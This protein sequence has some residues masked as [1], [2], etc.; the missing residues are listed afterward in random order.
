MRQP[1]PG[2]PAFNSGSETR[3]VTEVAARIDVGWGN[4]LYIRGQGA[5]LSWDKGVPLKCENAS[6]WIYASTQVKEKLVFK[7]LL[8]DAIWAH[9]EEIVLDAGEKLELVPEF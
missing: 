8:N 9:G 3:P 2:L 1:E 6:N 4:A 7:L 5:S